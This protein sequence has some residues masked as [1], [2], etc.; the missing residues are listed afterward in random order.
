MSLN[1]L[2]RS[3]NDLESTMGK[4]HTLGLSPLHHPQIA[5]KANKAAQQLHKALQ[6]HE[7]TVQKL[8]S[9]CWPETKGG[10]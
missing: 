6:T 10:W 2:A 5:G 3:L 4:A 7:S 8:H 9:Y 1:K